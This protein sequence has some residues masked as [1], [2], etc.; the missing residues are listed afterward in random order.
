[1]PRE[2][3]VHGREITLID[4]IEYTVVV[5]DND[6][7]VGEVY[8]HEVDGSTYYGYLVWDTDLGC[9]LIDTEDEAI[10]CLVQDVIH[11]ENAQ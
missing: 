10:D 6:E 7:G 11:Q 4:Q 1:M 2:R 8:E 9:E 3:T 5:I